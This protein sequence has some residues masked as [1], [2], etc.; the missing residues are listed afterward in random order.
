MKQNP[1]SRLA[2]SVSTFCTP[3]VSHARSIML[4]PSLSALVPLLLLSV[5]NGKHVKRAKSWK[6]VQN[7][8][9][10]PRVHSPALLQRSRVVARLQSVSP[11]NVD[12]PL[13]T[14]FLAPFRA[15]ADLYVRQ[16]NKLL[17]SFNFET[18]RSDN[19]GMAYSHSYA[20]AKQKR[21]VG[22]GKNNQ[23]AIRIGSQQYS[24]LRDSTRL[25]SKK[26]Y[27]V[28]NLF[29]FDIAAMPAVCGI[30]PSLW[31]TGSN[32]PSD[33]E[34]DVV[35]GCAPRCVANSGISLISHT[36]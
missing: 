26:K 29:I 15:E 2:S 27:N 19:G 6:L 30:W 8:S 32:W 31:F 22:V 1:N 7:L 24:D 23:V 13:F 4:L 10:S 9:V 12:D 25:V 14:H 28:G 35:E 36:E 18:G 17:N 16:G 11:G 34:I 3:A 33:G 5:V 21:L 20:D